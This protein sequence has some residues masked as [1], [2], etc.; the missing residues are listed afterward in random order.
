MELY[1]SFCRE[2]F[3]NGPIW[4]SLFC[5]FSFFSHSNSNDKYR[6]IWNYIGRLKKHRSCAW[7]SNLGPTDGRRRYGGRPRVFLIP[8]A[9][10]GVIAE[11]KLA[12]LASIELLPPWPKGALFWP[13]PMT[14]VVYKKSFR[15]KLRQQ[16]DYILEN[17]HSCDAII[18]P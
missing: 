16:T 8:P 12:K 5:L 6:L 2:F 9:F 7:D 4:A 13:S 1:S 17:N 11:I 15:G 3:W 18:V 10:C 14:K